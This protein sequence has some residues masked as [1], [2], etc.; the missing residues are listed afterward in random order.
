[1]YLVYLPN[2]QSVC[3]INYVFIFRYAKLYTDLHSTIGNT[4]PDKDLKW[5][6][7]NNGIDMAMNWPAF[8]VI[9]LGNRKTFALS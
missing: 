7:A 9:S 5:W 8:E 3:Q 4:D 2:F 6:S 1:M